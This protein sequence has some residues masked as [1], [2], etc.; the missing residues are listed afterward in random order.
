MQTIHFQP[1]RRFEVGF[2]NQLAKQGNFYLVS[3]SYNRADGEADHTKIPILF[4]PYKQLNEAG[5]H[6]RLLIEGHAA[7]VDI[8]TPK[9]AARMQEIC[10][11]KT[12]I[13]PYIALVENIEAVNRYIDQHYYE[14]MRSWV[15]KNRQW[16]NIREPNSLQPFFQTVM[17]EPVVNIK[18]GSHHVTVKLEELES[19]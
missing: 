18:W 2:I 14:Q 3:Q 13:I 1:Y 10:S 8:R 6:F 17:G 11:G 9:I 16:W 4:T 19:M 15:R 5:Q 12:D 7:M